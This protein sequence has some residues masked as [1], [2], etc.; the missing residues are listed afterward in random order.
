MK[1]KVINN[2][3]VPVVLS[4]FSPIRIWAI[5]LWPFVFCRGEMEPVEA[6]H[7]SI[8]IEQYNDTFLVGFLALYALDYIHGYIKYRDGAK[9]YEQI[10]AEQEAYENETNPNYLS[11]RK[12]RGW[13]TKYKV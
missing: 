8:H 9:A 7:E 4:Y 3:K 13:I 10:R 12:R 11:E 6:N 2:S 5:T 1:P